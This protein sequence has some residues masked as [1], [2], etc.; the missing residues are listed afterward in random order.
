VVQSARLAEGNAGVAR[1]K[2]LERIVR[3]ARFEARLLPV[4]VHDRLLA[5]VPQRH[6][7]HRGMIDMEAS[8]RNMHAN[9]FEPGCIL[10]VGAYRGDW[11]RMARNVYPS[12]PIHMFEANPHQQVILEEAA[13]EIGDAGCQIGLLG[14][15]AAAAVPFH[16][17][18]TGSSVFVENSVLPYDTEQ[19]AMTTLD[20]SCT[21]AGSWRPPYLLKMDVQGYELEILRGGERTL[22]NTEVALLEV[23]LMEYNR[24]APLFAEVVSF[25]HARNFVAYDIGGFYRRETDDTLYMLDLLFARADSALRSQKAFWNL[26]L[27][28]SASA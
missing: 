5:A 8:L 9:G 26:E 6:K 22:A 17:K 25:M 20:T 15:A 4:R 28:C 18:E 2:L 24:G 14:A 12:V 10:D 23:A 16:L 7:Y 11:S 21:G 19:L 13:G 1:T 27:H 3:R